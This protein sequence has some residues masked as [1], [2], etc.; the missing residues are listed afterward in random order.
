[1]YRGAT[2]LREAQKDQVTI[3]AVV[4]S[5]AAVG[6]AGMSGRKL[7]FRLIATIKTGQRFE[8][9]TLSNDEHKGLGSSDLAADIQGRKICGSI[10][11]F[12]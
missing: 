6:R 4:G 11:A 7:D 12:S 5:K 10:R 2:I 8:P 9:F 3:R 1:M